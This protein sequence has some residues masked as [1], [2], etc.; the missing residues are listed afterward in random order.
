MLLCV[1]SA[2]NG[3]A[4]NYFA[5]LLNRRHPNGQ[6]RSASLYLLSVPA[7][8]TVVTRDDRRFA[9]AAADLWNRL[10]VSVKTAKIPLQ[11]KTLLKTSF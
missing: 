2:L 1:Y 7:P 5:E 3:L 6:P 11:Y 8:Q 4:P 9:V 10:P